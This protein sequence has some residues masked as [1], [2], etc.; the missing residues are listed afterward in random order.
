[1]SRRLAWLIAVAALGGCVDLAPTYHRPANP[2][3][4]AF[5]SGPAYAPAASADQAPVGWQAF[6]SDSKLKRII[7]AALANNRD[8]RIAVANIEAARAQYHVQRAALYPTIGANATATYSQQPL[9]VVSGGALAPGQSTI[10]NER[11]YSLTAGVSAWQLDLFG[12][13]RNL[14]RAAQ[15]QYFA[16]RSARDAAQITLVGEVATDYLTLA[17]D[18]AQLFIAQQTLQSG[19]ASLDLT[20]HRLDA[21]VA[22]ALDVEQAKT[23]VQQATYDQA[24]LTTQVA[25]D[26]NALELVVGAPVADTDLPD[27]LDGEVVVMERLPAAVSS[28]VLLGRP[29]VVQ[30]ED[31]LRGANASIGAARANFFPSISLTGSGGLTSLALSSLFEG[32]AATWTFVP[33]ISQTIFDFG[34]NR[35]N[36]AYAK[37]ERDVDVATYEK[38]VQTAFRE[39]ADALAQRGTIDT[40]VAAQ[41]ALVEANRQSLF[42]SNARYERGADTYLNVLIAQR[43]YYAAQQT[44]VTTRLARSLNL[45]TLYGALGGGLDAPAG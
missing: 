18:R 11:L 5:P 24:R 8:L 30:A 44:L 14:T 43:A 40:Q 12:K 32:P 29:D 2:T 23:T 1:M 35:G 28:Q 4:A 42:L 22:S 27:T 45:V 38:A 34:A 25:Q 20:Q 37:A 15:D 26:R 39:V 6:F 36:L 31:V 10:Y 17:A 19:Q 33:T 3:P 16:T 13:T 7:Q 41:A 9:S 21:G